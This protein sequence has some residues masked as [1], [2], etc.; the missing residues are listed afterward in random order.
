[1]SEMAKAARAAMKKKAEKM[2]TA[3]PHQKVDSSTWTQAE[4]LN[5]DVKTGMRPVSRRAFKKG[6]K[7][8]GACA[9]MRADRKPRKAGGKAEMPTVDRF[10][11]KDLK[12]A[13][14]YREGI[15]H[16][17]ALKAGGRAKHA[18]DGKVADYDTGSRTGRGAVTRNA[19]PAKTIPQ[20]M[21]R[22]A[23]PDYDEG[24]HTG[25][26]TVTETRKAG[27]RTKGRAKK[28]L[29]GPMMQ[30]GGMLAGAAPAG[31]GAA[32]G[33]GGMDPNVDPRENLVDK[34]RFN[35]GAGTNANPNLKRGGK[36]VKHD[37]AKQ[38]MA[39]IKKMV[40]P[41]A[42]KAKGGASDDYSMDDYLMAK[43]RENLGDDSISH[44]VAESEARRRGASNREHGMTDL[45]KG[46]RVKR[47]SGGKVF[48]GEGYPHKIP[49]VVPG[50]RTA[51]ASGG[52]TGKGKTNVNIIIATGQQ[53]QGQQPGMAPPPGGMP[54]PPGG[55]PVSVPPP[56]A[57]GAPAPS[58]MPMPIPMAGPAG[59]AGPPGMAP[60]MGRKSGGRTF[61]SYKD[62]KAGAG[63]GDGRLEKEEIQEH[64]RMMR[65]DGGHVFPK[66]KF[67]AGS[68]EG[69]VEKTDKYGLTGSGKSR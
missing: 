29:G 68:G 61:S 10:I 31:G 23:E 12:K 11:N 50:G 3:D 8:E 14:E 2:T 60:P 20:P 5:A 55:L 35:F 53:G 58:I 48:S 57:A 17:G 56:P 66:M 15:K 4:P 6:G 36:A 28:F 63:S 22:P 42:R 44:S 54:K 41:A 1:M 37:D 18:T 25:A 49:G 52:K 46:G 51:H 43:R 27:G 69:R 45:K 47:E 32:M 13:N 24:S 16:V 40:K 62:M 21:R 7:V 64:K 9:P 67:G 34:S 19:A 30:P 26:G 59:P 33:A 65:K 39:L 38:D